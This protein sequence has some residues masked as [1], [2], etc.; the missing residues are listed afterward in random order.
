MMNKVVNT[1]FAA[2]SV[3]R[4]Q[5]GSVTAAAG[6]TLFELLVTILIIAILGA[7]VG[8]GFVDTVN[9]NRQQSA[10][11]GMFGMLATA[12]SE[13]V[14]RQVSVV[15]CPS[16]DEAT[17][18]GSNWEGGWIIYADDG[19]TTGTADNDTLDGDEE[20]IRIGQPASGTLTV[21]SRNFADAGLISFGAEGFADERGTI[22]ICDGEPTFA[23]AIVL[24]ISGQARLAV[25]EKG[26][27]TLNDD[28]GGEIATCP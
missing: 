25:D 12:R 4:Q 24:N 17:C 20:I 5:R 8:P 15:A 16:T 22:V 9:R 27:G 1:R 2:A 21:R 7:M 13:A 19:G 26:N 10:L 14:N 28:Q 18:A 6:F 3:R 11:G 23:S